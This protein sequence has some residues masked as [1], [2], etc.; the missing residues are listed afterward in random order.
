MKVALIGATGRVGSKI[1]TEALARNH[2]VTAIVRDPTKLKPQADLTI[3]TGTVADAA[4]LAGL[5]TGHDAAISAYNPALPG[6]EEAIGAII[7]AA[8]A[9]HIRL[10]VVGGAATLEVAPGTRVIDKPDFPAEWKAGALKTAQFLERLRRENA[11]DWTF[12]S[13][14][15]LLV[16]GDRTGKFRLGGDQVVADASGASR[17]SLEDYAVAM[18]DELEQPKHRRKRFT[19]GY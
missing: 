2:R 4:G 5:F 14:A 8:K 18:V 3:E 19:I 15:V 16:P 6:G 17:I 9:A 13:P 1:L 12:F 7:E 11:L 10:L